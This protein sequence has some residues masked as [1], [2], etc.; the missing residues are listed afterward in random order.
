MELYLSYNVFFIF[1][2]FIC[3]MFE[4]QTLVMVFQTEFE[5]PETE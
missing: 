4:I 1:Q 2:S 3:L 5:R